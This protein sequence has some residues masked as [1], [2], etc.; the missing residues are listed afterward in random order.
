M[1]K[2]NITGLN[3]KNINIKEGEKKY[4]SIVKEAFDNAKKVAYYEKISASIKG[5]ESFDKNSFDSTKF[6]T[7]EF[8]IGK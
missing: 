6:E 4:Y 2:K 1:L 7:Y 8:R 3:Q 5:F